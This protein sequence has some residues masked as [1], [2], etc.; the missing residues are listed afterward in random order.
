MN[1][2]AL[3]TGTVLEVVR[4]QFPSGDP[5]FKV[6]ILAGK[7]AVTE[8]R[9]TPTRF[10][11]SLPVEGDIVEVDCEISAYVTRR[12]TAGLQVTGRAIRDSLV[13]A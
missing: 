4:D 12:N 11:G 6:R 8:V 10:E 9:L 13:T 5:Y 1:V 2:F 3:V 7:S